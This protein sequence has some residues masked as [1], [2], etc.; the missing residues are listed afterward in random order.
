MGEVAAADEQGI[1]RLAHWIVLLVAVGAGL[2][3]QFVRAQ[4]FER[5]RWSE[6]MFNPY[7]SNDG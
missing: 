4:T 3:I 7:E 6:S 5:R 1:P 2:A